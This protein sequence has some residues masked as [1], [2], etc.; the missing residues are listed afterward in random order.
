MKM[1]KLQSNTTLSATKSS[2]EVLYSQTIHYKINILIILDFLQFMV[3]GDDQTW[4]FLNLLK[5]YW[6][7]NKYK[8]SMR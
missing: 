6:K 3:R 4:L 2:C 7:I 5:I 8:Y 1:T